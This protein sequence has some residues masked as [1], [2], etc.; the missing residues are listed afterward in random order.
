MAAVCVAGISV[1]HAASRAT[2]DETVATLVSTATAQR[3][4]AA[5]D[6]WTARRMRRARPA[7][8]GVSASGRLIRAADADPT[9][10]DAARPRAAI[11]TSAA[12]GSFP[13]RVH[14]KVF[15]TIA[16]G[17]E[18]GDFVCSAT[19]VSSNQRTLALTAGHCVDDPQ[20]GGGF[21]TNWIF[22][23][24]YSNGQKPFG[25]WPATALFTTAAWRDGVDI[26][27][28]FGAA[29]LVRDAN[30]QGIED[31]LG[32]RPVAFK[33]PRSQRFTAFGY[34]AQPT[35]FEPTFN[36]QRLYSCASAVS[37]SDNPP[38]TGPETMQ[39]DCDMSAGSSGGGWVNAAGAVNGLTSYSYELD[40]QHLYG[41][42]FGAEAQSFYEQ[43]S[44]PALLCGGAQVTNLG[45]PGANDFSG[46]ERAQTFRLGGD[47]DRARGFG[48]AD[49]AC[50]GGGDD[51]L[52]GGD[53]DDVLRG[54]NG[55]D[56]LNGGPGTD[57][58]IGGPGRDR[59][60]SCEQRRRI[61]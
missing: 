50:G 15:F 12:S 17:S 57:L 39:I 13:E 25:E 3:P 40:F 54:G 24:G 49:G 2:A 6:Y 11:D 9:L 41:P 26:R 16:G 21:A 60:P 7:D 59:G 1:S 22:V 46:D 38:G 33:L 32:A 48:A 55:D 10:P 27:Q 58:C 35:L 28:D 30:G 18:P 45:D 29:R 4:A 61:P 44:G 34:P 56:V 37:G 23:P 20:F 19:A 31:V 47:A 52:K 43:A 36:G 14:G 8:L 51:R 42:Y 53:A 5:R